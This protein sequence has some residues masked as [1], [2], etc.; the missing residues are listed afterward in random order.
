ME[1]AVSFKCSEKKLY[2]ILH[3]PEDGAGITKVLLIVTGGYQTRIGSHRL[4]VQ[5]A[6]ALCKNG[7]ASF[8]FDYEGLGDSEGDFVGF[9]FAG[10]SIG[11]ALDYLYDSLPVLKHIFVWALCDGATASVIYSSGDRE[12]IAGMILCNPYIFTEEGQARAMVK[13]YYIDRFLQ[14]KF[15]LKLLSFHF[16][17]MES[18]SSLLALL[19]KR[20]GNGNNQS[21]RENGVQCASLP[22][23]F[24]QSLSRFNKPVRILLS[25]NDLTAKAFHDHLKSRKELRELRKRNK[26][27]VVFIKNSNHTF[28]QPEAKQ[29]VFEETLNA[30]CAFENV[31]PQHISLE[32]QTSFDK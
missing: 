16:D 18:A 1:K 26:D 20:R 21:P 7:V 14:K 8:R 2:G 28:S 9:E 22:D 10:P 29:K 15:W 11:A 30:L 31:S 19:K 24:A 23:M 4:Y 13:H 6:R 12:R 5:L 17:Y 27:L 25:S 32:I 3:L